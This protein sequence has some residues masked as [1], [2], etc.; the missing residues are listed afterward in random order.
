KFQPSRRSAQD[1]VDRALRAR[2]LVCARE[3]PGIERRSARSTQKICNDLVNVTDGQR[4]MTGAF[5]QVELAFRK[6]GRDVLC[7]PMRK[8]PVLGPVPKG[9]GHSHFL[10]REPPRRRVDFGIGDYA[11]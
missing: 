7:Q 4:V 3:L 2:W 1:Q 6:T 8:R 10:E 11:V 5:D 9:D